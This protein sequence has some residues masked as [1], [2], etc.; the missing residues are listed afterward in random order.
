M[1]WGK[2]EDVAIYVETLTT[3]DVGTLQLL[4]S[5]VV[6]SVRHGLGDYVGT[7]RFYMRRV[8]IE[9]LIPMDV[10]ATRVTKLQTNGL[11]DED[12]RAAQAFQKAVERRNAGKSDDDPFAKD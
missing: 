2:K 3:T 8:D 1:A 4:R 12:L 9:A 10:L 5:L 6:R 7:E 11:G